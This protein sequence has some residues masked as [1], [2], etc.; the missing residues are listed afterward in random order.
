MIYSL[1]DVRV[2]T[3]GSNSSKWVFK[4]LDHAVLFCSFDLEGD[5]LMTVKWYRGRREFYRYS[6][7]ESPAMQIFPIPGVHVVASIAFLKTYIYSLCSWS[8]YKKKGF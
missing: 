7:M 1:K 4:K 8:K 5:S 2:S 6:P 3:P